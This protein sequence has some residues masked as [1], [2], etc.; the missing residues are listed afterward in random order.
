MSMAALPNLERPSSSCHSQA[1][2]EGYCTY[3]ASQDPACPVSVER[4]AAPVG[5]GAVDVV[6]AVAAENAVEDRQRGGLAGVVNA[7]SRVAGRVVGQ[8]AVANRHLGAT[9]VDA[10]AFATALVPGGG[11]VAGQGAVADSRLARVVDA[12]A[13]VGAVA[14]QSG[15]GRGAD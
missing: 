13:L 10:A 15:A 9:V 12:G 11:G 1:T 3:A 7:A 6:R 8:G 4:V 2:C 5:V 14:G